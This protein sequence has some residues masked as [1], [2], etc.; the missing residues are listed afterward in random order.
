MENDT[1]HRVS[2]LDNDKNH[3]MSALEKDKNHTVL[4]MENEKNHRV[5]AM[6]NGKKSRLS[7]MENDNKLVSAMETEEN[8]CCSQTT[9]NRSKKLL[10]GMLVQKIDGVNYLKFDL[11]FDLVHLLNLILGLRVREDDVISIGFPRSGNHWTFEIVSMILSQTTD[12]EK[13]HFY[14]RLLEYLGNEVAAN[15]EKIPSP[16]NL[17]THCRIQ[18]I[19]EEAIEK[20]TKLIYILRN[21]KDVLVSLY[22]F[23]TSLSHGASNFAGTWDEFFELQMLGEFPWGHWCDH[24]L[25]TEAYQNEHKECPIFMLVYEKMKENPAEEIEKLCQFL[26]KPSTLARQIAERTQFSSM[27]SELGRTKMSIQGENH[28]K[29]GPD[30]ILR[31]GV[32]GDWKNWFTVSQNEAFNQLFERKMINSKLG[33]LMREYI[34]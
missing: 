26:G 7:A 30:D 17:A 25:A 5:L 13:D 16:R 1:N 18:N 24:V 4:T 29:N 9:E 34:K 32:V 2:A 12:F 27:K 15:V 33:E 8:K 31:K 14:S 11:G 28:F 10:G 3:Q 21:P 22:K 20:R 23:T 6:E 19:P